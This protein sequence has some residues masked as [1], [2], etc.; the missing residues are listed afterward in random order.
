MQGQTCT[1]S[2]VQHTIAGPSISLA[3]AFGITSFSS[4]EA[5]ICRSL[6]LLCLLGQS[7][8]SI[9]SRRAQE[10]PN[11]RQESKGSDNAHNCHPCPLWWWESSKWNTVSLC[12]PSL[13]LYLVN[14]MDGLSE[15]LP[16][17]SSNNPTADID[18]RGSN[19]LSLAQ[20][21]PNFRYATVMI[22]Q[23]P[24]LPLSAL[25]LA[26]QH[27]QG[28]QCLSCIVHRHTPRLKPPPR[29]YR[30]SGCSF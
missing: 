28:G 21:Y 12:K 27:S 18:L 7:D 10:A 22:G 24:S 20:G 13:N 9:H 30:S 25:D 14:V 26:H 17:D 3:S 11:S 1:P 16:P 2:A 5:A 6:M 4:R 15:I 23:S 19:I 8:E 29:V